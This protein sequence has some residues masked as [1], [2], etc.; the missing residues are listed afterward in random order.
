[1]II[2]NNVF[3]IIC[4]ISM[5]EARDRPMY[6][7]NKNNLTGLNFKTFIYGIHSESCQPRVLRC[8][9]AQSHYLSILLAIF[10]QQQHCSTQKMHKIHKEGQL[11][12]LAITK[13]IVTSN[14]YVLVDSSK[15]MMAPHLPRTNTKR[16]CSVVD[17]ASW[18]ASLDWNQPK[19]ALVYVGGN[20]VGRR[21]VVYN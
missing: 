14:K 10:I 15:D 7:I 12:Q 21:F 18:L 17:A 4:C 2:N 13:E 6:E 8:L 19:M 1:M 5:Q 16:Y 20:I 3:I 9:Q 11:D